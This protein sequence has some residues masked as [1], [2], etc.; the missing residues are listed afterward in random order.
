MSFETA[1][2]DEMMKALLY[3]YVCAG[4]RLCRRCRCTVS[5]AEGYLA[6]C[7]SV[8]YTFCPADEV[9][10]VWPTLR[11]SSSVE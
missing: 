4:C 8:R 5:K 6:S 2:E 9:S 10:T 11:Q 1:K 3:V 7:G